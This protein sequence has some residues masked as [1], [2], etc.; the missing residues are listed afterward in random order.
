MKNE[1][2]STKFTVVIPTCDRCDTLESSLRTCVT[3]DYANLEIIVSDNFS[4]DNTKEVVESFKDSR[5]RYVNTGKRL[6]MADNWEFGLAH[7]SDGYV[8]I[9]G[10]DNGLLPGALID[11]NGIISRTGCEAIT[12]ERAS[13]IWPNCIDEDHRNI[14]RVPLLSSLVR[15][16]LGKMLT[17]MINFK[18]SYGYPNLY[19]SFVSFEAIQKILKESGR[20]FQSI[21]TDIY[22]GIALG[23]VVESCYCSSR[24]FAIDGI[25]HHS[26][27]SAFYVEKPEKQ[28]EFVRALGEGAIEFH[29]KLVLIPSNTIF[30]FEVLLQ[31]QEHLAAAKRYRIDMKKLLQHVAQ[32]ISSWPDDQYEV[33]IKA[34]REMAHINQLAHCIHEIIPSNRGK[35]H[36]KL[37]KLKP[38]LGYNAKTGSVMVNCQDFGV[39]NVYE[40]SLLCKHLIAIYNK[41]YFSSCGIVKTTFGL[42]KRKLSEK[43]N[44]ML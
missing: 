6:C 21:N 26:T 37:T 38:V 33:A 27:A 7:V 34:I 2:E 1:K 30:A 10:D 41:G 22:S 43:L 8:M 23:C 13:Y 25:S 44:S 31:A 9:L 32:E 3:Q 40:A 17:N 11:L 20:F 28:Q 14:M 29:S 4:Q 18:H 12:W 36:G 24:P 15:I 19:H 35:S 39:R 5:I 42:I 16:D